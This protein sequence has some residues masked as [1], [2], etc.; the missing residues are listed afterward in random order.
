MKITNKKYIVAYSLSLILFVFIQI[1]QTFAASTTIWLTII[2]S[3]ST[4]TWSTTTG[5][6]NTWSVFTWII[7]TGTIYGPLFGWWSIGPNTTIVTF[8]WWVSLIAT[9]I[10]V[11]ADK[12]LIEAF[13]WAQKNNITRATSIDT[14]R[15]YSPITRAELAKMMVQYITNVQ[16]K[17][18]PSNSQCIIENY[19]DASNMDNEQKQYIANACQLWIMWWQNDKKNILQYFRP[20]DTVTRA[21]FATVLSRYLY[22][23]TYNGDMS[24]DGWYKNHLQALN[25]ANYIKKIDTPFMRE[26][27]G[28]VMLIL[29][30]I[31]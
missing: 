28:F 4:T 16:K 27:R 8:S 19:E 25:K 15:L 12:E 9:W 1:S 29:Y 30:R 3:G 31:K 7:T 24:S 26:L 22:G 18:I 11:T 14:A 23:D 5:T 17:S 2:E 6:N 13:T 10:N 20:I 21:E